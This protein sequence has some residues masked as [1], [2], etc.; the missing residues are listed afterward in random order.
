MPRVDFSDPYSGTTGSSYLLE[1]LII[2]FSNTTG[3]VQVSS[4]TTWPL[5]DNYLVN[6]LSPDLVLDFSTETYRTEKVT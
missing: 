5:G 1:S 2:P 6:G 3:S 4:R